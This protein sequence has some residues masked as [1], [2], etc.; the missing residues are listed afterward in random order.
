M[1]RHDKAAGSILL[2][3]AITIAL[4]LIALAVKGESTLFFQAYA[5]M[6]GCLIVLQV[7]MLKRHRERP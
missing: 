2:V 7:W 5:L 6:V 3:Q 4:T 1:N